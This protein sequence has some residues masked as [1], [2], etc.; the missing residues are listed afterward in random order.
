[1]DE[2]RDCKDQVGVVNDN[3]IARPVNLE[4]FC[5]IHDGFWK[6]IYSPCCPPSAGATLYAWVVW[7]AMFNIFKDVL[8]SRITYLV[9]LQYQVDVDLFLL[10]P[11]F[12][13]Q[14]CFVEYKWRAKQVQISHDICTCLIP[15]DHAKDQKP[16]QV[17]IVG[18]RKCWIIRYIYFVDGDK[19][20]G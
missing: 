11:H 10:I 3:I 4:T 9:K 6:T 8:L 12:I 16:W 15:P 13:I 19:R 20:Q 14:L 5:E 18:K 17:R 2:V 1:M 7:H